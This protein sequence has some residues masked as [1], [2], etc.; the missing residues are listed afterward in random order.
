MTDTAPTLSTKLV[1]P[2]T[3]PH[4]WAAETTS[5]LSNPTPLPPPASQHT[6]DAPFT[7]SSSAAYPAAQGAGAQGSHPNKGAFQSAS[8]VEPGHNTQGFFTNPVSSDPAA[9]APETPGLEFPG[10]FPRSSNAEVIGQPGELKGMTKEAGNQAHGFVD[11]ARGYLPSE[12]Q[13]REVGES[14][15]GYLPASVASYLPGSSHPHPPTNSNTSDT[16]TLT[17]HK[18]TASENDTVHTRSLPSTETSGTTP[19]DKSGGAGAL[20]GMVGEEDVVK[21]GVNEESYPPGRVGGE[22]AVDVAKDY[23]PSK[24]TVQQTAQ[25]TKETAASYVPSQETVQSYVPSQE[26]A[27]SY[28]PSAETA[29]GY[30][31]S[32]ETAQSYVPSKETA[33]SY[34]PSKETTKGY[35][36]TGEGIAGAVKSVGESAKGYLPASVGGYLGGSSSQ[37]QASSSDV[38]HSKSLPSQETEG[39]REGEQVGGVGAL[40]GGVGEEGLV[41]KNEDVAGQG[42][43]HERSEPGKG[44]E[45]VLVGAAGL[46]GVGGF[47]GEQK[48]KA[49]MTR[50]RS[51]PSSRP[52]GKA[53]RP[54]EPALS[55]DAGDGVGLKSRPE[56]MVDRAKDEGGR[57]GREGGFGVREAGYANGGEKGVNGGSAKGL[58]EKGLGEK[59]AKGLG[60]RGGGHESGYAGAGSTG[61][62]AVGGAGIAE[63]DYKE[64][65]EHSGEHKE[66]SK[67]HKERLADAK[68]AAKG[69]VGVGAEE[70]EARGGRK[71]HEAEKK[72]EGRSDERPIPSES[73]WVCSTDSEPH[74][75]PS[76]IHPLPSHPI[77]K[78]RS[79]DQPSVKFSPRVHALG[80]KGAVIGRV[81]A[82]AGVGGSA[83][84]VGVGVGPD[85]WGTGDDLEVVDG[86]GGEHDL[87]GEE[88]RLRQGGRVGIDEKKPSTTTSSEGSKEGGYHP[89][90]LHPMPEGFDPSKQGQGKEEKGLGEGERA[91]EKDREAERTRSADSGGET[92]KHKPKFMDKIKGETKM[93]FGKMSGKEGKVEEGRRMVSGDQ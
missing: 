50:H 8:S 64:H 91:G 1:K 47:E 16:S 72:S 74:K 75:T 13:L 84:V 81:G 60:E 93:L 48:A 61:A 33:Q 87:T 67:E 11:S 20:P 85:E 58:G 31:P 9:P 15:K 21:R 71:E 7:H 92:Q 46:A 30:V 73:G 22:G 49:E 89:A 41:K 10:S 36:P 14:M 77:Q 86:T 80:G 65:K 32:Q 88:K 43:W 90:A 45:A 66:H 26:T 53:S 35:L 4:E 6:N 44:D 3:P 38:P 70:K 28:I 68:D 19:A 34:V 18:A 57:A 37:V 42:K 25:S 29:K 55:R 59:G 78:Q 76:T 83:R 56:D 79:P 82:G 17:P 12:D 24:D 69:G 63:R 40:P 62:G 5:A 52:V 51:D 2:G 39:A 23:L 27:A 54:S